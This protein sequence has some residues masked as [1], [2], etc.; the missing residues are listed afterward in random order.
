MA[1]TAYKTKVIAKTQNKLTTAQIQQTGPE[2]PFQRRH[3]S[4]GAAAQV[5][6]RMSGATYAA[7]PNCAGAGDADVTAYT[8]TL[9]Q[10][11]GTPL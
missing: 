8:V 7:T 6:R 4:D 10:F 5:M 1:V 3:L 2:G 11:P 9:F